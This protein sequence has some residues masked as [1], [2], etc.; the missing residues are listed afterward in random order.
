MLLLNCTRPSAQYK[1]TLV[2]KINTRY[3]TSAGLIPVSACLASC[4]AAAAHLDAA[5]IAQLQQTALPGS[6]AQGAL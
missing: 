3:C 2:H 4:G 5:V 1:Y 6:M